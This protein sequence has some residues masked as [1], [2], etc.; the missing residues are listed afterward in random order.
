MGFGIHLKH[1]LSI[2]NSH[3]F[4]HILT[5]LKSVHLVIRVASYDCYQPGGSPN[6]V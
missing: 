4:L 1:I 6:V 5:Y 3:F 2:P